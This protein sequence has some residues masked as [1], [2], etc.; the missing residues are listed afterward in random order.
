VGARQ[1]GHSS[2]PTTP[3]TARNIYC[4]RAGASAGERVIGDVDGFLTRAHS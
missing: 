1:G 3:M 4:N 2:S